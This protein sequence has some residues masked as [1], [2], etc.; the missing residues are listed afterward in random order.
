MDRA[1]VIVVGAGHNGLICA[2]YLARAG[3]ETMLIDARDAVGGLRI[4]RARPRRP[5]QHLQLRPRPGPGHAGHRRTRS[6]R[7][8]PRVPRE[9]RRVRLRLFH[10]DSDPWL[11][12]HDV[13]RTL[14]SIAAAYPTQ[15]DGYRRYLTDALP[16]A[17][18]VVDMARRVP[19]ARVAVG[20]TGA[21]APAVAAGAAGGCSTGA[22]AASTTCSATTS[23]TGA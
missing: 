16:I 19:S 9:R 20:A 6:R 2:A 3:I 14:D 8:R 18:L 1:E 15:V 10:D 5:V 4:D 17:E 12:F 23:T 13:E 7:T 21:P 22:A 11:Q